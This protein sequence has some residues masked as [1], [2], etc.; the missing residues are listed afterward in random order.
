MA[1]FYKSID[2]ARRTLHLPESASMSQIKKNYKQLI[3]KWHPDLCGENKTACEKMT[4]KINQ[5]YRYIIAYCDQYQF[6]FSRE[7]VEKYI[8]P[9][10]WW[11]KRFGNDPLWGKRDIF[12]KRK[13]HHP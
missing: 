9:E 2:E 4:K 12:V 7:E 1:I 8:S 3:K 6:S 11:I 10:E 5:A 13:H